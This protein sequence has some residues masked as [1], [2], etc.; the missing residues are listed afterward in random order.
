MAARVAIMR[1]RLDWLGDFAFVNFTNQR[2][3]KLHENR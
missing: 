3:T 1:R 2:F